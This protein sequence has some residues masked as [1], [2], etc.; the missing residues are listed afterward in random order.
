MIQRV[1]VKEW[2]MGNQGR[3]HFH[4]HNK[5]L[6]KSCVQYHHECCKRISLV[7]YNLEVQIKELKYEVLN[8]M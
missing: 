5:V 6:V 7:L 1:I 4:H 2:L 8:I 3:I